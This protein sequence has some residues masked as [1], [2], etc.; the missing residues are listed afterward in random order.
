MK[1]GADLMS[2]AVNKVGIFDLFLSKIG[3]DYK[4][5]L[6]AYLNV[7]AAASF[8]LAREL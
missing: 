7:T 4:E 2:I 6:H 3:Y 8:A 1:I 5:I